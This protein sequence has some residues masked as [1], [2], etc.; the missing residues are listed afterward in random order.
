MLSMISLQLLVRN[1]PVSSMPSALLEPSLKNKKVHLEKISY[2][3]GKWNFLILI[4]KNSLYFL[5]ANLF[6]YFEK[7][8]PLK[9]PYISRNGTSYISG[10]RKPKKL[11]I[12]QKVIL[13][14]RKVKSTHS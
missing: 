6:L 9:N 3:S 4:L 10:Y 2:T 8:K 5:E 13:S 1:W 11:L 12:F 14:A 7:Q